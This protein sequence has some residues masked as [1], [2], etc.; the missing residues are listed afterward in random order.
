MAITAP[1]KHDLPGRHRLDRASARRR[2]ATLLAT[3]GVLVAVAIVLAGIWWTSASDANDP[4]GG[5]GSP[6]PS[7]TEQTPA[8]TTAP[9]D[10]ASDGPSDGPST[11]PTN[12]PPQTFEVTAEPG[13]RAD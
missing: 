13:E 7:P 2:A 12:A 9:S 6:D 1:D 10:R 4:A 8:P 3:L 5:G 11:G